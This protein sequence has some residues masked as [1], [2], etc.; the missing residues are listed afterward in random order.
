MWRIKVCQQG[1]VLSVRASPT[2][3][4]CESAKVDVHIYEQWNAEPSE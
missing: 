4:E 2:V 1:F 3:R